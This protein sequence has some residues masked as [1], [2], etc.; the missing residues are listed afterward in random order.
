VLSPDFASLPEGGKVSAPP[1]DPPGKR[2]VMYYAA[3]S[4]IPEVKTILSGM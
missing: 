1:S 2:K 3:G 4:G